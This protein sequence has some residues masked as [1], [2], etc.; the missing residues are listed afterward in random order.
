MSVE[1]VTTPLEIHRGL[2]HRRHLDP[3]A[4]MLFIMGRSAV[5]SFYMRN[6]L[7][8]LD[9]IFIEKDMS[10]VG[11]V[12]EAE[13]LSETSRGVERP[14][15]FVLEVNGGWARDHFVDVGAAVRVVK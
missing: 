9:M 8:S 4:G 11:V 3:D 14:S 7:I 10:V 15:S 6:T 5:W 2:M 13:P 1:V 12:H